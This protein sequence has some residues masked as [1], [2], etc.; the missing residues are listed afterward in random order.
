MRSQTPQAFNLDTIIQAYEAG[1]KDKN[2]TATD[3]CGIVK[4]YLPKENIFIV[5]GEEKNIK[6]THKED[7]LIFKSIIHSY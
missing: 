7:I 2:F 5:L 6:I 4:N 1:L 3:D